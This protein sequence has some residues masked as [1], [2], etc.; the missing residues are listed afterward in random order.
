MLP[1]RDGAFRI[2]IELGLPV[3]PIAVAGTRNAMARGSFRFNRATAEARVLEPI[4]TANLT[5]DDVARL[6]DDVRDRIAAARADLRR[7]IGIA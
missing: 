2:A 7:E 1:F 3:L 4:E 5:R 6:R